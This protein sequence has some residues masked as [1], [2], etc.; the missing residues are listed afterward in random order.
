MKIERRV[1]KGYEVH[2]AC[3]RAFVASRLGPSIECPYCGQ[4]ALSADLVA[5]FYAQPA[6][7]AKGRRTAA[8]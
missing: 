8:A 7:E 1:A 2:C 6:E 4:T 3:N 5:D